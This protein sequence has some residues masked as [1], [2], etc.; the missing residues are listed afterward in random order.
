MANNTDMQ[1][2]GFDL[3]NR[4]IYRIAQALKV[5]GQNRAEFFRTIT[6]KA[7]DDLNIPPA[8][9]HIK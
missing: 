1:K 3:S 4:T 8:P 7:L 5:T 6:E 2:V 9:D